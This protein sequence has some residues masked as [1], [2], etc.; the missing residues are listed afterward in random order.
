MLTRR[1]ASTRREELLVSERYS[2]C[3]C[4]NVVTG[5]FFIGVVGF[6]ACTFYLLAMVLA[7]LTYN[8]VPAAFGLINYSFLLIAQFSKRACFYLIFIVINILGIMFYAAVLVALV[9][10][11]IYMPKFYQDFVAENIERDTH[12]KFSLEACRTVTIINMCLY[13]VGILVSIYVTYVVWKAY[14]FAGELQ[15]NNCFA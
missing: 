4:W 1:S 3:K 11:L 9:F 14:K 15:K 12:R 10:M 6:V 13:I 5:A 2:C 7:Q 8:I